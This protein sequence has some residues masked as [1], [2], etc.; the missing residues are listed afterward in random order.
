MNFPHDRPIDEPV[1]TQRDIAMLLLGKLKQSTATTKHARLR[2]AIVSAIAS[3]ELGAGDQLPPEAE[4]AEALSLSLGTVR[5]GLARLVQEGAVRR[6]HGRG[7]FIADQK[8]PLAELWHFHLLTEDGIELPIHTKQAIDVAC[9]G[10]WVQQKGRI[11]HA[12][13]SM[14]ALLGAAEP[15]DLIGYTAVDA[16]VSTDHPKIEAWFHQLCGSGGAGGRISFRAIGLNGRLADIE[17]VALRTMWQQEPAI[18]VVARDVTEQKQAETAL[19]EKEGEFKHLIEMMAEGAL[20][21]RDDQ[22]VFVNAAGL[23]LFGTDDA[24]AVI[25]RPIFDLITPGDRPLIRATALQLYETG[26]SAASIRFHGLCIDGRVLDFEA[27]AT[28]ITWERYPAILMTLREP[29]ALRRAEQALKES[30][31]RCRQI[32]E[33]L[34]AAVSIHQD[35]LIVYANDAQAKLFGTDSDDLIGRSFYD[36]FS[37]EDAEIARERRRQVFETGGPLPLRSWQIQRPDCGKVHMEATGVQI[38]WQG[39]PAVLGVGI[40]VTERNEL[41]QALRE[42]E[43][44]LQRVIDALP[45]LVSY[46]DAEQRYRLNNQAYERWFGRPRD[47]VYGCHVRELLGEAAYGVLQNFIERALGGETVIFESTVPYVDGSTRRVHATYVPDIAE[48]GMVKGFF[49]VITDI[50]TPNNP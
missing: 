5:R 12:N 49:A 39:K 1:G 9:E 13:Q 34:P 24:T 41:Q 36:F 42:S 28:R 15:N 18:L 50:T 4:L 35:D 8:E 33:A 21:H 31:E 23:A 29:V 17:A 25:G 11:V 19:K 3:G 22:I 7:T 43:I 47:E 14:A 16:V 30:E 44:R 6:E 46:V 38:S 27:S 10:V 48:D 26:K 45:I 37:P 32:L 40:D 2:S 20:V